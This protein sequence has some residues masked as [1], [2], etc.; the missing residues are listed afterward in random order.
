MRSVT[1]LSICLALVMLFGSVLTGCSQ[2]TPAPS[3][4]PSAAPAMK[5]APAAS[6]SPAPSPAAKTAAW[7]K[8]INIATKPMPATTYVIAVAISKMVT[9]YLKDVNVNVKT[10]P[11]TVDWPDREEKGE[12]DITMQTAST[13]YLATVGEDTFKEHG[14]Y[15]M[16]AGG[17]GPV[18][19]EGIIARKGS[20]IKTP[21]DLKGKKLMVL[22]PGSDLMTRVKDAWLRAYNLT[23]KDVTILSHASTTEFVEAVKE[24]RVDAIAWPC[25]AASP[26]A[27]ELAQGGNIE[28]ISDTPEAIKKITEELYP[29]LFIPTTMPANTYKGQ[30]KPWVTAGAVTMFSI[31]DGLSE[32]FVYELAKVLWGN[33]DEWAGYHS[34]VEGYRLPGSV[35]PDSM[36]IP[37]H[38]GIV[39]YL[40]EKGY[41]KPEQEA[42]RN[43]VL[44]KMQKAREAFKAQKK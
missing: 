4:A 29:G 34:D 26:W 6:P 14:P 16:W 27:T 40:K 17:F 20:G 33:F 7:P 42:K 36:I 1:L 19:Y 31:R 24:G 10:F 30:D 38:P 23:E 5:P 39:K 28:F 8:E 2:P 21:A 3:P 35:N 12:L 25:Y 32:D 11:G 13:A 9:K 44:A 15:N 41:W 18:A 43:A 37:L 22:R